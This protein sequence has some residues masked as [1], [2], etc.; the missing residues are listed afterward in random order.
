MDFTVAE[1]IHKPYVSS[2]MYNLQH[3]FI[4]KNFN[5]GTFQRILESSGPLI[6]F[7]VVLYYTTSTNSSSSIIFSLITISTSWV[8]SSILLVRP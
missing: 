5:G 4:Q 3:S 6:I 7:L 8:S 1:R 2:Y